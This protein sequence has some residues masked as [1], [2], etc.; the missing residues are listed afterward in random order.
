MGN[1]IVKKFGGTS[2]TDLNRVASLIKKDVEK[3]CNVIVVVSAVAGFTDQMAFQ[4]RQISNLSCRQELS[5]YDV[6]LSAGEQISCGLLAITL[7]SMGINAKSWLAWQLPIITNDLYSESK[8]KT[9]KIDHLKRSFA[10]GYAVAIIAGFQGIHGDRITTFGRG[11]SDISAVALAVVFDV[12]ICEIFTDIDGIYTADPKIVPKARKLKSISYNEML[13]ISSSGAKI[14]HNRSIQLA[15]KHNIRVQVLSTFKNAEG[16]VVLHEKD[17][18]ER[19]VIT[20]ITCSTN[21]VLVTFTNLASTL[22]ILKDMADANIK[23]DMIHGSSLVISEFDI[24]L[25][26]ELLSK[27]ETHVINSNVA[28]IS[29]IGIGVMSNTE[30][31]HRTLKVLNKKK[32][33]ILAIATSEIKINIIVQ[34]ECAEALVRDLHTELALDSLIPMDS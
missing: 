13:E 29:V 10:E 11:G 5:E 7:Q 33:E 22:H 28:R 6:I 26:K 15:M 9:I 17:V 25:M 14:L 18:L 24:D 23:I 34:K 3:G 19:Y 12:K 8:I 30:V 20:G 1:V 27:N 16:T 4:A 32:I 31:M 2:L 21:E